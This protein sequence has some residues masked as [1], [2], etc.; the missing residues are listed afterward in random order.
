MREKERRL[1]R[2]KL[3]LEMRSYRTAGRAK[4]PTNGLLRAVRLALRVP[5]AEIAGKMGVSRSVIWDLEEGERRNTISMR[6]LSRMADAMGCKVV[7]GIVP[8]GGKKLEELAEERLWAEVLGVG[9][10]VDSGQ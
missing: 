5:L 3:D 1:A 10:A 2:M 7:Y 9:R 4:S 6:S 8:K